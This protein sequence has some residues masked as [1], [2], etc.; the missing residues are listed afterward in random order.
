VTPD[1]LPQVLALLDQV[2]ARGYA[3]EIVERQHANA[4]AALNKALG[5]RAADSALYELANSLLNRRS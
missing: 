5:E 1:Q 2:D 4:L 3:E